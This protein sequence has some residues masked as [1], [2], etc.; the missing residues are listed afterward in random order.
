[1]RPVRIHPSI[2][3]TAAYEGPGLEVFRQGRFSLV[4]PRHDLARL[5]NHLYDEARP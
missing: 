1:M 4:Y 2:D 3:G 5:M